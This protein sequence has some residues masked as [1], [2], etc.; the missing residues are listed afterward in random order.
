MK[1]KLL[2]C[3]TLLMCLTNF[4]ACGNANNTAQVETESTTVSDTSQGEDTTV[5]M[6]TASDVLTYLQEKCSNIGDYVEYTEETDT[7]QLLGRP[8]QYTSKINVAD[9]R[10]EQTD[11][12]DPIGFSIEV[13][14][15]SEDALARQEY[16]GSIIEKMPMMA[17]YDYINDYI[18]I[19]VNKSLTPSQAE[20]YENALKEIFN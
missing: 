11:S 5:E 18:L 6:L 4:M 1:R 15:N 7:N 13:F 16:I 14:S 12:D 17:E 2:V 19:R 10:V 3:T 8:N 20:E 9:T